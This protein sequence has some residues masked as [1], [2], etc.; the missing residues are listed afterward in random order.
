MTTDIA[1]TLAT[2][3]PYDV[4]PDDVSAEL[5]REIAIID[6]PAGQLVY[7]KGAVLTHLYLILSGRIDITDE[8]GEILSILG[9]RNSFG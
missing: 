9:P 6:I 7:A 4:L 1:Q 8:V 2:T 3:H 5:A